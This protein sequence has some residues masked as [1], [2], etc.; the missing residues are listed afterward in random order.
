ME[1]RSE[2]LNMIMNILITIIQSNSLNI[3]NALLGRLCMILCAISIR[4]PIGG[5][6]SIVEQIL[7]FGEQDLNSLNNTQTN[8]TS[9]IRICLEILKT[10]TEEIDNGDIGRECKIELYSELVKE[11]ARVFNLIHLVL[12]HSCES[13]KTNSSPLDVFQYRGKL[14][15]EV[16]RNWIVLTP[17]ISLGEFNEYGA[18]D[19]LAKLYSLLDGSLEM[20]FTIYSAKVIEALLEVGL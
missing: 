8:N 7:V 1:M 5:V 12:S 13:V 2:L 11:R 9:G 3:N 10:F 4:S 20:E 19:L 18:H 16:L 17:S 14:S 6:S 15:L